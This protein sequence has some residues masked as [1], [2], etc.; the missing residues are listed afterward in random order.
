MLCYH[1]ALMRRRQRAGLYDWTYTA[2]Y[3]P[4]FHAIHAPI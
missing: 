2:F 4:P 1:C 3:G